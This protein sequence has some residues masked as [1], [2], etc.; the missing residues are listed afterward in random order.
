VSV[1]WSFTKKE[2]SIEVL[3]QGE[4]WGRRKKIREKKTEE[5]G[6]GRECLL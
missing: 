6:E 2:K 1:Y 4:G 3:L 5:W